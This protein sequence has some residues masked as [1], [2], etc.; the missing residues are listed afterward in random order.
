MATAFHRRLTFRTKVVVPV[1]LIMASLVTATI[2]TVNWRLM[3][4]FQSDATQKLVAADAAFQN[5][6]QLR[7]RNLLLRYRNVPKEPRF[8]AV[9]QLADANT[10]HFLLSELIQDLGG[11]TVIY[12]GSDGK[13]LAR[14]TQDPRLNTS[15]LETQSSVSMN[16]AFSGH[17][18]VDTV[19]AGGRLF[20]VVSI[21]VSV[22]NNIVGVLTFSEEIGQSVAEEFKQLTHAEVVF[23]SNDEILVSTIPITGL[24]FSNSK[25]TKIAIDDEPFFT[26]AGRFDSL[27][28]NNKLGYALLSSYAQSLRALQSA[29]R[30]L[31]IVGFGGILLGTAIVW[32]LVRKVTQPLREL[33]ENVEAVGRGDFSRRV[34]ILARD[35]CGQL[36]RVFNEMTSNLQASR[37]ELEQ[38]LDTLKRT[39]AQLVQSEKLSAVG[40]FVSGV[41]HELNNPL[42]S[43][44]GF[45]EL[46]Q[47]AEIDPQHRRNVELIAAS[48]NRCHKIVENLLKFARQHKP[49]RK[50][51]KVED[52]VEATIEIL[53][54]QM[55]TS[56]IEVITEFES[57]LPRVMADGNQL[58]QVFLNLINNARH[59][60]EEFRPKGKI[61]V[62][63]VRVGE[64]MRLLF[65]D[66]GPGITRENLGKIFNPFFTTKEV[67]KGTGLGLSLS[68]GIIQEHGG[69]ITA[70]SQ[71]GQ[72]ATFIIDLPLAAESAS[73]K[74][75]T[76]QLR[77]TELKGHGRR[78]LV[79]DDEEMIL[80]LV[81]EL[82]RAGGCE[83]EV[84]RDGDAALKRL[85]K[86][87]FDAILCDWRMPG[88]N[89]QQI[90][91]RVRS[92]NPES[93][94][95]FIFMTGDLMNEA[96][97][98]FLKETGNLCL[99]KPFSLEQLRSTV[100]Q[101]FNREPPA[102]AA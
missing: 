14:A 7:A 96:T 74:Q 55:R 86:E 89:G 78:V 43:V 82:L 67:G 101:L 81:S 45:A 38:T 19:V 91:E 31:V 46:M 73:E 83:L 99:A 75:Q 87:R 48:A 51:V 62:R 15:L 50:P 11:E 100:A 53:R 3:K 26:L 13:V 9:S 60:I 64:W 97:Q 25:V 12:T 5:S 30:M 2:L 70:H 80:S 52:L 23:F 90:Y 66:D 69:T 68:Y 85:E 42:T 21:P 65:Q 44:V 92:R 24:P 22:G 37:Q 59:A 16:Q 56:N 27:S 4:A 84:A 88:L 57:G 17:A 40:E 76:R 41:A 33:R 93:A 34:E 47:Q 8:K 71:P 1:V 10:L 58:Q 35:E 18:N 77:P 72:G 6:Q 63:I 36:A 28:Q 98:R 29:Q 61:T 95:R 32:F 49:E 79:I 54:Y 94:S 20:D 39:Q 102:K